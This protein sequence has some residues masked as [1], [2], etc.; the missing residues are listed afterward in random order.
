ML[1]KKPSGSSYKR[2]KTLIKK[3]TKKATVKTIR[4]EGYGSSW[5]QIS[6]TCIK[7]ADGVCKK[8]GGKARRAHHI[9][10]LSKGGSNLQSNLMAV[11][12]KCHKK[13]H[14]HLR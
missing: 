1:F 8:C 12:K 6:A 4:T 3:T 9:I 10:P 7:L 11:C 5:D 2:C 14:R 13:L